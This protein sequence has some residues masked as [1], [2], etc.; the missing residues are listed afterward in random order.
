MNTENLSPERQEE[1]RAAKS[2]EE[3]E[4][5]SKEEGCELN[6]DM[7][8]GVAGGYTNCKGYYKE[9]PHERCPNWCAWRA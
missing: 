6:D 7:L 1:L 3:L 4:R 2:A 5:I 9:D 8:E